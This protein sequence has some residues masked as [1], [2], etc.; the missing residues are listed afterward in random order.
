MAREITRSGRQEAVIGSAARVRGRIAGEG[1]LLVEGRV[2]GD[3]VLRGD[4]RVAESGVLASNV[5]AHEVTVAGVLEGDIVAS[6][7]V[8]V[9]AGARLKGN[10][11]GESVAIDE[12][13]EFAGRLDCA[14]D[15]PPELGGASLVGG[16]ANAKSAQRR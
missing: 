9:R 5:E 15:L 7:A 2:E 3:V 14:F 13:A 16:R 4:L 6:G 8:H 10:V 11:K 1:D 12:G